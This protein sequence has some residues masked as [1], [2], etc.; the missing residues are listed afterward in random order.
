[1]PVIGGGGGGGGIL[2]DFSELSFFGP[3]YLNK[4]QMLVVLLFMAFPSTITYDISLCSQ[5]V[6]SVGRD[7]NLTTNGC[8]TCYAMVAS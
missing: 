6:L 3:C 1:M 8:D 2:W 7:S 5:S 4:C